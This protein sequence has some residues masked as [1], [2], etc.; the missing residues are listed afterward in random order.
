MSWGD[1]LAAAAAV[2]VVAVMFCKLAP[3]L[4]FT[5]AINVVVVV[6]VALINN[7]KER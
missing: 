5:I 4:C 2:D 7:K 3:H 6:I 1:V